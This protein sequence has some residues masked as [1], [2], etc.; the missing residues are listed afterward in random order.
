VEI[1][2]KVLKGQGGKATFNELFEESERQHCDVL[3]AAL[4]SMYVHN[5]ALLFSP[6]P[7][8]FAL[9]AR[10]QWVHPI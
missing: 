6:L 10:A 2:M 9:F 4:M 7:S 8:P 3:T 5:N 1:V